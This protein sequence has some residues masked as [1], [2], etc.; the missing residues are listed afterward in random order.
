MRSSTASVRGDP[1]RPT[2]SKDRALTKSRSFVLLTS[3]AQQGRDSIVSIFSRLS[4]AALPASSHQQSTV[5]VEPSPTGA[6]RGSCET[7]VSV[8]TSDTVDRVRKLSNQARQAQVTQWLQAK[9]FRDVNLPRASSILW[10]KE[11]VYPIHV[12]AKSGD[13]HLLMMLLASGADK[14]ALT[15]KGRSALEV[16]Q[17]ADKNGSHMVVLELL[18][19]YM[20]SVSEG[21]EGEE[22]PKVLK[23]EHLDALL[24]EPVLVVDL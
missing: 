13:Q 1:V 21:E 22:A 6:S 18:S 14:N 17:M 8:A 4:Q 2:F 19:S 5:N 15:S 3:A 11:D 20:F 16:A 10:W 24:E 12:A 7:V 9:N 23:L